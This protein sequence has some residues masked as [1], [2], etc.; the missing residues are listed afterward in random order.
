M[1]KPVVTLFHQLKCDS[2]VNILMLDIESFLLVG[3]PVKRMRD[4]GVGVIDADMV[5]S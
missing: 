3:R 2:H 1:G 4:G 5:I